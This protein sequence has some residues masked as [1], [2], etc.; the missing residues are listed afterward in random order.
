MS[1][2]EVPVRCLQNGAACR[3]EHLPESRW[4]QDLDLMQAAA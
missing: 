4:P 3:A 2:V 1:I